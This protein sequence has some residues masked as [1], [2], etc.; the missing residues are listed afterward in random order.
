MTEQE[1]TRRLAKIHDYLSELR[2]ILENL[3]DL[4]QES[5]LNSGQ[6]D[7]VIIVLHDLFFQ[8]ESSLKPVRVSFIDWIHGLL[9]N[10]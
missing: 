2:T 5:P 3:A 4:T 6:E 1:A 8:I 7:N 10:T 9:H